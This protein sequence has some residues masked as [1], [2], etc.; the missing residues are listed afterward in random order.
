MT[1][2]TASIPS[3]AALHTF[4]SMAG[5]TLRKSLIPRVPRGSGVGKAAWGQRMK[6]EGGRMKG[7]G[8]MNDDTSTTSRDQVTRPPGSS[9]EHVGTRRARADFRR[10]RTG[11]QRIRPLAQIN[12]ATDN[13]QPTTR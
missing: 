7:F 2:R 11:K 6:D 5:A 12:A 13:R 3:V 9:D 1:I 10:V 8:A 4:E